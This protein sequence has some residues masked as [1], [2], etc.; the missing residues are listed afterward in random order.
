MKLCP[1]SDQQYDIGMLSNFMQRLKFVFQK[2]VKFSWAWHAFVPIIL[3]LINGNGVY[4]DGYRKKQ[5]PVHVDVHIMPKIFVA[6]K[7][8]AP[9][10]YDRVN[11]AQASQRMLQP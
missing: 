5:L 4:R 3:P 8:E 6:V 9:F 1:S 11:L 2:Q 10:P 7:T